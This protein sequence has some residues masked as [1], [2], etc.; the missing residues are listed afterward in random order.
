MS[1]HIQNILSNL[2]ASPGCYQMI[3][4]DG[5]VIYVGKAKDLNKRVH[6]YFNRV[7][8]QRIS[9]MV[10]QIH[11]I[12]IIITKT[13]KEALLL[14]LNLI[15]K[16]MPPFNV[17]LKDDRQYPYIAIKKDQY[18]YLV[19]KRNDK[20]KGYIYYG[21]YTSSGAAWET[22][23][24]LNRI[25]PLRKCKKLPKKPCI[26]YHLGQCLAPCIDDIPKEKYD[27]M[28]ADINE[29]LLGNNEKY[30]LD[31]EEKA[32]RALLENN[33]KIA[34][35]FL[36]MVEA[37]K[38][39]NEAQNVQNSDH[40]S[41]DVINFASLNEVVSVSI[42]NV[43]EGK[44]IG[45][46]KIN[47]VEASFDL[48][49]E[50]LS[51]LL[52]YYENHQPPKK[53]LIPFSKDNGVLLGETLKT[54]VSTRPHN[55][56]TKSLL[57]MAK[58]NAKQDLSDYLSKAHLEKDV[59][60]L[61]EDLQQILNLKTIPLHIDLF[62][63]SHIQGKAAVGAAISYINGVPHKPLYRH[64]NLQYQGNDF[65][66]MMDV[67]TR[68]LQRYQKDNQGYPDLLIVDGGLI[69]VNAAM[70]AL[71]TLD[72][73]LKVVGLYKNDRHQTTGLIDQFGET[74]SLEKHQELFFFLTRMQDEVH[75]FAL[76]GHHQKKQKESE[77]SLLDHIPG[78]G[79][80][81]MK[82]LLKAFPTIKSIREATLEELSAVIPSNVAV[83]IKE[84]LQG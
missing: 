8:N 38:H 4:R 59:L 60:L 81:R 15:H 43:R 1:E 42:L 44:L 37:I 55:E 82:D 16:L 28:L 34:L 66:N 65:E 67:I 74:Y 41:R 24:L 78:L 21:P 68:R 50:I 25:F 51:I 10:S 47:F 11:D 69:Q 13:E 48:E 6:Q 54:D 84:R 46:Q 5:R 45:K 76:K 14:E 9:R 22:I 79:V 61:L 62:D 2:P 70:I 27:E 75:R 64:Y 73:D 31:L 56:M 20:Q 29:F 12:Q 35:D 58:L 19:L 40:A 80:K 23:D 52:Q 7:Q 49:E 57:E 53:I 71:D 30:L 83:L 72:L 39:I 77:L 26:Y 63:N 18:P 3:D 36:D 17:L 32:T 33:T